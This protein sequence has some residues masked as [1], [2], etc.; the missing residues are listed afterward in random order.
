[1][2]LLESNIT[3]EF[4]EAISNGF[5]EAAKPIITVVVIIGI[6]EF[7]VEIIKVIIKKKKRN[8]KKNCHDFCRN[9]ENVNV[10]QGKIIIQNAYEKTYL[11]TKN[12]WK[13]YKEIKPITDKYNLHILAKI[14][15]ND[16][17]NVKNDLEKSEYT[18]YLNKIQKKHIDFALC[19]PNNLEIIALVELDDDTHEKDDRKRRDEFINDICK[20]VGY[21]LIRTYD[22]NNFEKI[23]IENNIINNNS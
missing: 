11:L 5:M 1:M 3:P 9:K 6:I 16:L 15:L 17:V 13:F 4:S 12:E 21:I 18:K 2:I 22:S 14:R 19:N 8:N 23:L 20:S 7:L 10:S